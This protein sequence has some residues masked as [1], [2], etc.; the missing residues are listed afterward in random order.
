[1]S[2]APFS[3]PI[4]DIK[5]DGHRASDGEVAVGGDPHTQQ[6][7]KK[8][9]SKAGLDH[10]PQLLSSA[11]LPHYCCHG[12]RGPLPPTGIYHLK[13]RNV[14]EVEYKWN[15]TRINMFNID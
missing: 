12:Q 2:A 13:E 10:S 15:K 3:F 6:T 5:T 9:V 14:N 8:R 1:M 4:G 11:F 7:L